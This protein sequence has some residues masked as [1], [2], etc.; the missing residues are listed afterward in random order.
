MRILTPALAALLA[1]VV[2]ASGAANADPAEPR[3]SPTKV[4][5]PGSYGPDLISPKVSRPRMS[6]PDTTKQS[7]PRIPVTKPNE[8]H[9]VGEELC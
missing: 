6:V 3:R 2:F 1:L 9:I 8:D 7:T 4:T 5:K